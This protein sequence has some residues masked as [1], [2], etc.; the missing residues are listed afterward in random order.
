LPPPLEGGYDPSPNGQFSITCHFDIGDKVII[1]GFDSIFT[2]KNHTIQDKVNKNIRV[3]YFDYKQNINCQLNGSLYP[4][5][6]ITGSA[7][8]NRVDVLNGI[9]SGTF[10]FTI[11]TK[12]CGSYKIT[13][14]RF[15][16][17]F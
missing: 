4:F 8:L 16:Y 9:F 2:Y 10:D 15:D 1:V 14:G 17:K 3:G 7:M 6:S 5:I 12:D 11:D 13:N